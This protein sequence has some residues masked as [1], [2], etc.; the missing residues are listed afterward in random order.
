MVKIYINGRYLS[1]RTTGQQRFSLELVSALD[2]W[3]ST[4]ADAMGSDKVTILAPKNAS[5]P[6]GLQHIVARQ[7]GVFCGHLWEQAELPLYSSDGVLLSL[8][9]VG[10][11]LHPN[12]VVAIHDVAPFANPVNFT[13]K[14][15]VLYGALIPL[16]TRTASNVITVSEFSKSELVK[17]LGVPVRKQ[18]V[19]PNGADHILRHVAKRDVL[20]ANG[21]TPGKYIF[22]LGS[23][24]V[25]KNFSAIVEAFRI[26]GDRNLMLA[27]GGGTNSSVFH[28]VKLAENENIVRLGYISD[29]ELR[30]LY[31][32]AL[33]FVMPS[34]YE[35][36]GIP[37]LEAMLCGCPVVVST[38][39][40]L[41]ETCGSAA[42]T[43]HPRNPL[44]LAEHIALLAKNPALRAEMIERG[45]NRS[46]NF[47]WDSS[48]QRL[49]EVLRK[50]GFY[51]RIVS[52]QQAA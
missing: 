17:Y 49:V 8:C 38:I 18:Y 14:F 32:N 43:C 33:C 39:P 51:G 45:L 1:Q 41:L 22:A 28:N 13:T 4:H 30:A 2:R 6:E 37:P 20:M 16:L 26:L 29:G 5:M 27:V 10:P 31:E 44:E 46:R 47:T 19:I 21:L 35:G 15:R 36:F 24:S 11:L 9:G 50:R 34:L 7:V 40:A 23:V 3:I 12:H 52:R 42:L 25:N 48:G